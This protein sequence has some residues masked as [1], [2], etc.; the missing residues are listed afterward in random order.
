M[1]QYD[2][3]TSYCNNSNNNKNGIN[4]LDDQNKMK[5][6]KTNVNKNNKQMK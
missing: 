2:R 5:N 1:P 3:Q 4:L 6:N